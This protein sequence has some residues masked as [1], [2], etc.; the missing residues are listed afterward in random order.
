MSSQSGILVLTFM[1]SAELIASQHRVVVVGSV[2]HQVGVPRHRPGRVPG[3]HALLAVAPSGS[4]L[5]A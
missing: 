4:R 2:H 1:A 3:E 5:A